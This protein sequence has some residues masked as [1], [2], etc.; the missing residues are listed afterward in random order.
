MEQT[1]KLLAAEKTIQKQIKR[2]RNLENVLD[3][4]KDE[5]REARERAT[6]A[7]IAAERRAEAEGQSSTRDERIL[8]V[9]DSLAQTLSALAA[10]EERR[11]ARG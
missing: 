10:R 4:L 3:A 6:V 7:E 9:L 11:P 5:L 8:S 1:N 2:I